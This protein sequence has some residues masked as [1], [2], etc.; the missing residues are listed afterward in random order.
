MCRFHDS[1]QEERRR[2]A[3]RGDRSH[4]G[5]KDFQLNRKGKKKMKTYF[6]KASGLRIMTKILNVRG[7]RRSRKKKTRV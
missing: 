5:G 1:K 3:A 6:D 2:E 4:R 7:A